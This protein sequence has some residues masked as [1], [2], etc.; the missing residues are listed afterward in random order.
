MLNLLISTVKKVFLIIPRRLNES[1]K[2]FT[3]ILI[4]IIVCIVITLLVSSTILYLNFE[5]I[6]LRQVY[7]HDLDS[8][9]QTSRE[10]AKMTETAKALSFQ[11]Y[12]DTTMA[13]LLFY[14]EP[15]LY[16]EI[17]ALNQL[18]NYRLAMPFIE[19]IYVYNA[20]S[21][22]FYI[23]SSSNRNGQQSAQDLDDQGI[24]SILMNIQ[25]YK[26]FVPI[27]R[28]YNIGTSEIEVNSYTYLCYDTL[29]VTLDYGVIVNF[30][31]AWISQYISGN[32]DDLAGNAFIIDS[33]GTS[34]SRDD[35]QWMSS[36]YS[37]K[38]Y[39]EMIL[40][41]M[42][43]SYFVD[44]VNGENSLITFTEPDSMGWRYIRITS[45]ADITR[46]IRS[47]RTKTIFFSFGILL[48]GLFISV[49][50]SKN[51]H[52]P[53]DKIIRNMKNLEYERKSSA[54]TLKQEILRSFVL[55]RESD[56]PK[57]L[58]EK[59][60]RFGST[61][62]IHGNTRLVLGRINN[63][64]EFVNKYNED[65]Y[66]LKYG[67]MNICIEIGS[68]FYRM[69]GVDMGEDSILLLLTTPDSESGLDEQAFISL[70]S[71]M[72]GSVIEHLKLSVSFT[73]SPTLPCAEHIFPLYKQVV[74]AS[75][76]QLFRGQQC[77]IFSE[78]I[79][80]LNSREYVYPSA[81]EKQL[82]DF[83]M[84][85]KT[86]EAKAVYSDIIGETS[87]Y[88]I[89]VL[90]L[91]LS[92][93]TLTVNNVIRILKQNNAL[94]VIP[95][96]DTTIIGLSHVESIDEVNEQFYRLFNELKQSV[97]GKRSLKHDELVRRMNE[98]IERD[99]TSPNL[100]LNSIADELNMSPIYISR[101]Y[102]QSTSLALPDVIQDTRMNMA[103]KL[104]LQTEFSV[105]DIA[106]KTGYTSSSYFYRIFKK[107]NG[108]TP[109]DFRKKQ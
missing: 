26:P 53:I 49:F 70:L 36:D 28:S 9:Q 35:Q 45:Y 77:L 99:Y 29:N 100:G 57:I 6:A 95:E 21:N 62:N 19:S 33:K 104:L 88:S 8:L 2:L 102:K 16:K 76:H 34:I 97:E 80:S 50:A 3:K 65:I 93:L 25:N 84:S 106:E 55:G 85:G 60:Q 20:K 18:N 68:A 63:F 71:S 14:A 91:T 52:R 67:L 13:S 32:Q 11:I 87:M 37:E 92:H 109:N 89:T 43:S 96:F 66:L 46:E 39:M 5:D 23:S 30:S 51:L 107:N 82:V 27:P 12:T 75:Y 78:E 72:Q 42:N 108:V 81:K 73:V 40:R 15:D 79:M 10:V 103:K 61:L 17:N 74:E 56:K 98:I 101:L 41:N 38:P 31:E 22:V 47:M 105:A 94:S 58:Q 86:E 48:L 83:L 64:K 24:K 4:S 1:R 7:R 90:Q 44:F 54:Y 59:L 69:E